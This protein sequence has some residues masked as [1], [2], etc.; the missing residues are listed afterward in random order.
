MSLDTNSILQFVKYALAGVLAGVT[1]IIVFHL[2]AWKIFP[3]LQEKDHAV[4]FFNLTIRKI[5][6]TT[7]AR[8]S[9]IS[10]FIAFLISNMVAYITNIL[11]VFQGGKYHFVLE[12]FLFYM[13]SGVSTFLGTILMG[14]LIRRFGLLTT[15]A[16]VSNIF[17]AVMFNYVM[18]KFFIFNG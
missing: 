17:T 12:I 8:N 6:D 3:A 13:V 14:I 1:H 5:N 10:N 11:F 9:M 2:I 16:F 4:R 18:R 15:Y 7:R